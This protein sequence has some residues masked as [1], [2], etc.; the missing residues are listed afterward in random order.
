MV[1]VLAGIYIFVNKTLPRIHVFVQNLL[2][3]ALGD[4]LTVLLE[5]E[6]AQRL[7]VFNL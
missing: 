1:M 3:M 4:Q 2:N 7:I 6:L 5:R